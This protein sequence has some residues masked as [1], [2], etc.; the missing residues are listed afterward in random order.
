MQ[1]NLS[2]IDLKT[3]VHGEYY[4]P[5]CLGEGIVID[6]R[7]ENLDEVDCPLCNCEGVLNL[8]EDELTDDS[9]KTLLESYKDYAAI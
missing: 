6:T 2:L 4:C 7:G 9:I 5:L 8:P 1:K 3:K